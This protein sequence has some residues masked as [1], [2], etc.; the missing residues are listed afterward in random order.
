M[1]EPLYW[2]ARLPIAALP[3]CAVRIIRGSVKVIGAS[4]LCEGDADLVCAGTTS[5]RYD[6]PVAAALSLLDKAQAAGYDHLK[7]E[8]LRDFAPIMDRCALR[9]PADP[10]CQALPTDERLRR[11]AQG[12]ADLGLI[13]YPAAVLLAASRPGSLPANQGI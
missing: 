6:D 13:T 12:Q 9:L 1:K 8:H 10:D 7:E 4:L 3:S 2:L 11:V 5:F